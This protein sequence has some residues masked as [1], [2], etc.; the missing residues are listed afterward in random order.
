MDM[1][2]RDSVTLKIGFFL[3]YLCVEI[4]LNPKIYVLT[5]IDNHIG[6]QATIFLHGEIFLAKNGYVTP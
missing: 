3:C 5:M 2:R 1:S 4:D 6:P